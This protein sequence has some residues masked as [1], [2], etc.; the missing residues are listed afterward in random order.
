MNIIVIVSCCSRA[1]CSDD[2]LSANCIIIDISSVVFK[3][4]KVRL[5]GDLL[6]PDSR[7]IIIGLETE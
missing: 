6:G 1:E 3:P 4:L 2:G 5:L 7:R